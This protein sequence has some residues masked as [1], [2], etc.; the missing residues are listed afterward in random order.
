MKINDN[1]Q[2][3]FQ[4]PV[5]ADKNIACVFQLYYTLLL[6]HYSTAFFLLKKRE[7]Q[8]FF[9][10]SIC[11]YPLDSQESIG[12]CNTGQATNQPAFGVITIRI[13]FLFYFFYFLDIRLKLRTACQHCRARES[14]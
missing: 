13:K 1:S 11:I 6:T 5:F 4:S 12:G 10:L 3:L 7:I 9:I 2:I 8:L 14:I